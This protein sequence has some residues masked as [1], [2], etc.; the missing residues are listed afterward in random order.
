MNRDDLIPLI[1]SAIREFAELGDAE[2]AALDETTRLVGDSRLLDSL[3][4]VSVLM[5][6]EQQVNDTLGVN[7][8]IADERAMSQQRSPF[9]SVG[10]LADYVQML[11]HEQT[12]V[13]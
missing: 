1:L 11:I 2:F 3:G 12:P 10:A 7:I 9:R 8:V 6:I 13:A 4:L 5:D